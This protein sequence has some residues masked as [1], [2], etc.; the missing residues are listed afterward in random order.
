METVMAGSHHPQDLMLHMRLLI[1]IFRWL[2]ER[3]MNLANYQNADM[4]PI[5]GDMAEVCQSG[6]LQA[7]CAL[8]RE[9]AG[10]CQALEEKLAGQSGPVRASIQYISKYYPKDIS[11]DSVAEAVGLSANYLGGIF[12]NET[13]MTIRQFIENT[14][15]EEAKRL[16][17]SPAC[18][19]IGIPQQVG[20]NSYSYFVS[21]FKRSVG[22]TPTEYRKGEQP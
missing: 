18:K 15:I 14:R 19:L 16:I 22:L 20:F 1:R 13:G 3:Y 2:L 9:L 6:C 8:I 12:K 21:V 17:A 10:E 11:L 4:V 7:A 5:H